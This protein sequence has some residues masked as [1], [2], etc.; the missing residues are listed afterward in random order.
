MERYDFFKQ[1]R[2]SSS[3]IVLFPIEEV[4]TPASMK[5]IKQNWFDLIGTECPKRMAYLIYDKSAEI[6]FTGTIE[7]FYVKII[8]YFSKDDMWSLVY[9]TRG[10]KTSRL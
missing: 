5:L 8:L 4:L 1:V 2:E 7:I 3:A 6:P 10:S 9:S